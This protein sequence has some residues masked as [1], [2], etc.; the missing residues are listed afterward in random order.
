LNY[1]L[2]LLTENINYP[3]AS[4]LAL[5]FKQLGYQVEQTK[6]SGDYGADLILYKDSKRIVV[7]CKRYSGKVSIKS[8][9]E[10]VGAKAYYKAHD[11]WS[12]TNSYHTNPAKNLALANKVVLIERDQLTNLILQVG[13]KKT[14]RN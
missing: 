14:N 2:E 6:H 10:A 13:H 8:I 3:Y 1:Q 12:E 4:Y 7:Q 5:L 11:A 9:Q